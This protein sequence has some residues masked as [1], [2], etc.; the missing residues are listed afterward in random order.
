M[1][2]VSASVPAAGKAG[3]ARP[4]Q[5]WLLAAAWTGLVFLTIPVARPIQA[6]LERQV[7]PRSYVAMAVA[8]GAMGMAAALVRLR[9]AQRQGLVRRLA[10]LV[11]L[12][13]FSVWVL[14]RQLQ[15]SIEA[16]HFVEYG[17]LG[18][19]L[20]RAWRHHVPD[21]LVYAVSGLGVALVAWLDEFLQWLA[22]GR[23]WDYRD[24]R[25]NLMAGAAVLA[26]IGLVVV[27]AGIRGPV[28]RRS[29]RWTCGLAWTLLLALGISVSITPARADF[30]A[31]RIPFLRFLANNPSIVTEYGHRFFDPEIGMFQ[32][33]LDRAALLRAD[34]ERGA[35]AGAFL[36]RAKAFADARAFLK[37]FPRSRDPYLH[38]LLL[39]VVQRDHYYA[40]SG[41]YRHSDPARFRHHLAVAWGENQI[42]EK[43]F[44]RGLDGA[45][46]R[47]SPDRTANCGVQAD[48]T[49]PFASDIAYQLVVAV[50]EGELRL[51][52]M[53]LAAGVGGWGW[54]AARRTGR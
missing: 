22:P 44:S 24:I 52:L 27:P 1:A 23:F 5:A 18:F 16:I 48:R 13:L 12:G 51:L 17:I 7:G 46:R 14:L 25:L 42:L 39:H 21:P 53:A 41:Q 33:R 40:V 32:S 31:A 4:A 35:A 9:R 11:G 37:S 38:E 6:L 43:Y 8:V 19:L 49:R 29:I 15:S 28:G 45:N 3:F 34:R 54:A 30:V 10:W 50:S 2:G 20:F 47:W 36:L 26:F